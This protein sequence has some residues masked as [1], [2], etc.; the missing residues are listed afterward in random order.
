[1]AFG[2]ALHAHV[3]EAVGVKRAGFTMFCR[4]GRR[5]RPQ[6]V[7]PFIAD[8]PPVAACLGREG[9]EWQPSQSAVARSCSRH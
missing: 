4:D 9:T 1:M 6:A 7:V 3:D 5:V 8:V 2:M